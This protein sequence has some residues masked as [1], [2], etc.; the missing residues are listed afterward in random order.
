M[1]IK[2][3]YAPVAQDHPVTLSQSMGQS[4][5]A[6]TFADFVDHLSEAL[7]AGGGR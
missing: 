5:A 1:R 7:D 2:R 3:E 6:D 4:V